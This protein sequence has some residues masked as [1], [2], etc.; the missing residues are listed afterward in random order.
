MKFKFLL[1]VLLTSSVLLLTGCEKENIDAKNMDLKAEDV[2]TI[3]G[4]EYVK[5]KVIVTDE[6]SS[7]CIYIP[8][9][10]IDDKGFLTTNIKIPR[11]NIKK[12]AQEQSLSS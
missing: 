10:Y 7:G 1:I 8:F 12:S 2:I 11:I 3:K 5:F 4:L 9:N 6:I